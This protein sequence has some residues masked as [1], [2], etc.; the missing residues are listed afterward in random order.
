MR[1]ST[2]A[3]TCAPGV[4]AQVDGRIRGGYRATLSLRLAWPEPRPLEGQIELPGSAGKPR[5]VDVTWYAGGAY[6]TLYAH[7]WDLVSVETA[8]CQWCGC[9]DLAPCA[10]G[11]GACWWVEVDRER[12]VG[13]CSACASRV[14][15]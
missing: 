11:I 10:L 4:E 1:P 5:W 15:A 6:T 14:A 12:R 8:Q 2:W 3:S 9:T 7:A 13:T